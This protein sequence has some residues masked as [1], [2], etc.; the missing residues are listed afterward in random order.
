M[1]NELL[2]NTFLFRNSEDKLDEILE[3]ITPTVRSFSKGEV[4]MTPKNYDLRIGFILKGSCLVSK[5]KSTGDYVP[6]NKLGKCDSFGIISV[7]SEKEKYPTEIVS[8]ENTEVVFFNKSDFNFLI[9]KRNNK[10]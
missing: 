10:C 4:I 9:D 1:I 2:K 5:L 3:K 8:I 6:L 7:L